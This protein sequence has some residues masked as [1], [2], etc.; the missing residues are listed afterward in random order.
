MKT[1]QELT[2]KKFNLK[3][4]DMTPDSKEMVMD[5]EKT[6][7]IINDSLDFIVTSKGFEVTFTKKKDT[8]TFIGKS[9]E[10]AIRLAKKG[11]K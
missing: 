9:A 2:E 5:I 7:W 10:E 4:A 3:K 6:G 11:L 8:K 1:Y